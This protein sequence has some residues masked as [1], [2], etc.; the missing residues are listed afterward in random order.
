MSKA[1][2]LRHSNGFSER[3]NTPGSAYL[4]TPWVLGR[5]LCGL[6]E[7]PAYWAEHRNKELLKVDLGNTL[8]LVQSVM[9]PSLWAVGERD[10]QQRHNIEDTH[11][12]GESQ[13]RDLGITF[14][15]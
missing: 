15:A 8:Q 3:W 1:C 10:S 11:R 5:E 9:H 14:P 6:R 4:D 13:N 7:S 2:T 12:E